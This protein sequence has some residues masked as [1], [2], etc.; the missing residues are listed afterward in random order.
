MPTLPT[1]LAGASEH[2]GKSTLCLR[3]EAMTL[4]L[5]PQGMVLAYD[6]AGRLVSLAHER[7][8]YWRGL[9]NRVLGK[10]RIKG[11]EG[12]V[13]VRRIL[14]P[15]D[16]H[17][18][19][20]E[21]YTALLWAVQAW[22]EGRLFLLE[23]PGLARPQAGGVEEAFE[24]CLHFTPARLDEDGRWFHRVYHRVPILP[25][26]QYRALV[27]QATLGCPYNRC[28]FCS[29]YRGTSY[30]IRTAEEFRE[31]IAAVKA[32]LGAGISRYRSVFLGDAN[33][34]AAPQPRLLELLEVLAAELPCDSENPFAKLQGLSAFMDIFLGIEKSGEDLMA[35]R[36]RGLCRA[37]IGLET[38]HEPL[39]A[40]LDKPGKTMD[41]VEVVQRLKRANIG[42]GIIILLGAGGRRY[43]AA[44]IRDTLEALRI[45]PLDAG[46][47]IYL[48][49]LVE[50]RT[51]T[52]SVMAQKCR[53]A[54]LSPGE[55][56][57]QEAAIR[58]GIRS[59]GFGSPPRVAPYD[60]RDF[61]Y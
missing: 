52:Y 26:D 33:S 21:A 35:L 5:K 54:P 2:R 50:E 16:A 59:L 3:P 47:F 15:D 6:R 58:S 46:D 36:R 30:H 49:P 9:D 32:F 38:G 27:L 23:G 17:R 37:Y 55:L 13:R 14:A 12:T 42:L 4:S 31:H 60:I 22:H 61:I 18:V 53:I 28:N 56:R 43:S 39:L 25:P 7:C 34:I 44:H 11:P 40:L 10:T 51:A 29:L 1:A 45:M 8:L 48:S 19:L 20:E 57:A 24:R 41:A